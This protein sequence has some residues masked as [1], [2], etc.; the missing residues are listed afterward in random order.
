[1]A[2]ERK[3]LTYTGEAAEALTR[4]YF[5]KITSAGKIEL[6]DAAGE[7]PFGVVDGTVGS[8]EAAALVAGQ[9][10]VIAGEAIAAGDPINPLA[11][12]KAA[13]A[14]STET[15]Y[16]RALTAASADG[17]EI[18]ALVFEPSHYVVA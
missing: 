3:K 10:R 1:M 7:R 13:V 18:I 12:G 14:A 17:D 8:G 15:A 6:C 11:N 9:C 5:G 16:G 4:G 2:S